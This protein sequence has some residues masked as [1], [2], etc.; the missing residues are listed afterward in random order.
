MLLH[1]VMVTYRPELQL[2][3]ISGSMVL[4]QSEYV[5]MSYGPVTMEGCEDT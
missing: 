5:L 3:I 2:R 1:N 4:L